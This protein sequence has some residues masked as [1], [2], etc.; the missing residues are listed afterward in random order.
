M[1]TL[2]LGTSYTIWT[3]IGAVG[4]FILGT[5][6]LGGSVW[7][8]RTFAALPIISSI[9]TM[10]LANPLYWHGKKWR[11][12]ARQ[13]DTVSHRPIN[14]PLSDDRRSTYARQPAET[15]L[16]NPGVYIR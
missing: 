5:A 8:T 14:C 4:V 16:E 12:N 13:K 7:P 10:K 1:K 6:V 3:G 11:L 2:P 9:I 15:S